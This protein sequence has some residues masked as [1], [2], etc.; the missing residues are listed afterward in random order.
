MDLEHRNK[1]GSD[2]E[3]LLI[4]DNLRDANFIRRLLL[5]NPDN[6]YR[7]TH[8]R[9]LKDALRCASKLQLAV[10][11][12]D[13]NLPD[14]KGLSTVQ[15]IEAAFQGTPLIVLSDWEDE[16]VSLR[17]LHAGAQDY[18]VKGQLNGAT[19]HRALR[20]AMER[21]RAELELARLAHYDQL[22]GLANR[23]LFR[24]TLEQA[25]TRAQNAGQKLASLIVGLDRFK[26]VNDSLG[27]ESGDH[28]LI[29]IAKR[30]KLGMNEPYTIA[31]LGGDEFAVLIED[32]ADVGDVLSIV[33]HVLESISAPVIHDN[34]EIKGSASIGVSLYPDNGITTSALLRAADLAMHQAK[35]LGSNRSQF[36][37]ESMQK[38]A[39]A[40][41]AKESALR[42][43]LQRNEFELV[44]QPQ[45]C[46][47]SGN[48]IGI[49]ALLRWWG[50][51]GGLLT[52]YHF[53]D[54]LEETGLIVEVGR[55]V[56]RN[57]CQQ[58]YQWHQAGFDDLRISVNV[59]AKQVEDPQFID[60]LKSALEDSG[61]SPKYLELELTESLLMED[62]SETI[63]LL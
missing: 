29:E 8:V 3:V 37:A 1:R 59:S 5:R 12:S 44:Y 47:R 38:E 42:H 61:L 31:R 25:I 40:R 27:H 49:E 58:M 2:K 43:A 15:E 18:I 7:I 11:V 30:L 14:S 56:L 51:S 60:H 55:W 48:T 39:E 24:E 33:R 32:V 23:K 19:L 6:L 41:H 4:E 52:P 17:A 46:L 13:L 62:A 57:A 9:S 26:E 54:L 36:F 34:Q 63:T 16:A 21:K 20:Y 53:I 50:P 28:Y 45:V 10:I 35:A 22:T